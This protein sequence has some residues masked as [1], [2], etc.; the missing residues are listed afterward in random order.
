MT[1]DWGDST[2]IEV[3]ITKATAQKLR[4]AALKIQKANNSK[5]NLSDFDNAVEYLANYVLWSIE[6]I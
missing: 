1:D 2:Y 6:E 4:E 5:E 3:E